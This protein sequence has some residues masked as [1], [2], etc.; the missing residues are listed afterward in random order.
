MLDVGIAISS[1][2]SE[3]K[4]HR[5]FL[6]AVAYCNSQTW[7]VLP[8]SSLIFDSFPLR[9]AGGTVVQLLHTQRGHNSLTTAYVSPLQLQ[10][11]HAP[12][13]HDLD[14]LDPNVPFGDVGQDLYGTY[15]SN[16]K[17]RVLDHADCSDPT[18]QHEL[19]HTDHTA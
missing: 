9:K 17:K 10:V 8:C 19:D 14:R 11:I 6:T 16:P 2:P 4:I 3:A 7:T 15:I 5:R 1:E 13:R 18:R 12:D